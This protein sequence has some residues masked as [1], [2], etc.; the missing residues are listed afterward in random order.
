MIEWTSVSIFIY[1][2]GAFARDILDTFVHQYF[3][4]DLPVWKSPLRLMDCGA[5]D[6]VTLREILALGIPNEAVAAYEP[7]ETSCRNI[8]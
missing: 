6:G 5:Y 3:P 2:T 8:A 1:G 4:T 7:D